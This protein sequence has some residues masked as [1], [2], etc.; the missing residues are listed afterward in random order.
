[1]AKHRC[2]YEYT[3]LFSQVHKWS[4]ISARLAVHLHI[5]TLKYRPGSDI[6][7]EPHGGIEFHSRSP[8]PSS[9]DSAPD[10]DQCWL[11]KGPCWHDG[12]SLQA[13]EY[14]IPRW[15]RDPNDHEGMFA[16]LAAELDR[17]D[18]EMREE[19]E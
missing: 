18:A 10:H 11:L 15:Q 16:A 2:K 9:P 17:K 13:S 3:N 4:V 14:W 12:S 5:R 19:A 6:P 1:M 7:R 8:W